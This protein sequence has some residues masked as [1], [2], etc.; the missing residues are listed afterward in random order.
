MGPNTNLQATVQAA[1]DADDLVLVI[2]PSFDAKQTLGP[3]PYMP[4]ASDAPQPGDTCLVAFDDK[5]DGWIVAF[6]S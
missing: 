1:P 2:A 3:F 5:G 4:R 6:H